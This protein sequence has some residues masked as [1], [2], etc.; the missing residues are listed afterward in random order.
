MTTPTPTARHEEEARRLAGL[1][2]DSSGPDIPDRIAAALARAA[3]DAANEERE[4]CALVPTEIWGHPIAAIRDALRFLEEHTGTTVIRA[5]LKRLGDALRGQRAVIVAKEKELA[6]L[7]S[8]LAAPRSP[9]A[10]EGPGAGY[11]RAE[12]VEL[13]RLHYVTWCQTAQD[14]RDGIPGLL[15]DFALSVLREQVGEAARLRTMLQAVRDHLKYDAN[16]EGGIVA[17]IDAALSASEKVV[18]RS[19][20]TPPGQNAQATAPAE[21]SS[22]PSEAEILERAAQLVMCVPMSIDPDDEVLRIARETAARLRVLADAIR[23]APAAEG[24][25]EPEERCEGCKAPATRHDD[26]GV[27]LCQACYDSLAEEQ[28]PAP[29]PAADPL[30]AV[31]LELFYSFA[32][33]NSRS[34][35]EA[36]SILRARFGPWRKALEDAHVLLLQCDGYHDKPEIETKVRAALSRPA[37]QMEDVRA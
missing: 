7:R 27:P 34:V 36:A 8:R 18:G 10:P 15:A 19:R 24:T 21:S 12:L 14:A 17:R 16:G 33:V 20:A 2:F 31:A 26:E 23:S 32:G 3:E 25:E 35:G 6:E 37:A 5:S 13:A 28:R 30:D 11:D 9:A 1:M 22:A 4:R 29:A